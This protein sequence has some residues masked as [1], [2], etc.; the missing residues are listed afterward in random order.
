MIVPTKIFLHYLG[1]LYQLLKRVEQFDR[2]VGGERL[3]PEMFPLLQQAKIAIGFTGDPV[4]DDT[5]SGD[6][7]R[8]NSQ[9][10]SRAAVCATASRSRLSKI[11]TPRAGSISK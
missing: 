8:K 5:A 10:F 6:T 9:R 7:A 2:D 3:H 4:P 1:K 11:A